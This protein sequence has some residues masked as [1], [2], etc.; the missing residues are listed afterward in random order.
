MA[1]SPYPENRRRRIKRALRRLLADRELFLS[2]YRGHV[3]AE[4][5]Y[6]REQTRLDRDLFDTYSK[7]WQ[8]HLRRAPER[9]TR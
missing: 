6:D 2:R 3:E 5:A 8:R 1:S 7:R 4:R 9:I